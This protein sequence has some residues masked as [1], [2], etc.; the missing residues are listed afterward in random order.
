MAEREREREQEAGDIHTDAH[1]HS[2]SK[3]SKNM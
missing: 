3:A 2:D 1:I